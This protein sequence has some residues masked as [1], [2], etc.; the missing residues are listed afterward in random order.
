MIVLVEGL[1]VVGQGKCKKRV[2]TERADWEAK[3][4]SEVVR[5]SRKAVEGGLVRKKA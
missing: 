5:G 3:M 4:L 1:V 2:R